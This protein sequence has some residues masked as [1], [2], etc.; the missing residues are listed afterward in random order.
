VVAAAAAVVAAAVATA[1]CHLPKPVEP[2][3]YCSYWSLMSPDDQETYRQIC[4]AGE[5][6]EAAPADPDTVLAYAGRIVKAQDRIARSMPELEWSARVSRAL[7]LMNPIVPKLPDAAASD[8]YT[9]MARLV[10]G[11][12]GGQDPDVEVALREAFH[13][14]PCWATGAMVIDLLHRTQR[15]PA[16]SIDTC[17]ATYDAGKA[18][19]IPF[20]QITALFTACIAVM[21][22]GHEPDENYKSVPASYWEALRSRAAAHP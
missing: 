2:H 6:A 10:A 21:P 7:D 14:H 18:E 12:R 3:Q 17:Q 8:G 16:Y 5:R 11:V 15:H 20:P 22:G 4:A 1:G 9:V 13:R 19:A